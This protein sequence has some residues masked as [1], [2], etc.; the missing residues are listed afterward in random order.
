LPFCDTYEFLFQ[1]APQKTSDLQKAGSEKNFR[2][3]RAYVRLTMPLEKS[4]TLLSD[5]ELLIKW[6]Y[7]V[8]KNDK[9]IR[10]VPLEVRGNMDT[11][12]IAGILWRLG[13]CRKPKKIPAPFL[14]I[15]GKWTTIEGKMITCVKE[16]IILPAPDFSV[17]KEEIERISWIDIYAD[18]VEYTLSVMSA[19]FSISDAPTP[20]Y[21]GV[22]EQDQE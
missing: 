5:A 20:I 2:S 22:R 14:R 12:T 10:G 17:V 16:G 13:T 3:S 8:N 15:F 9:K 4:I 6:I 11:S 19:P 18:R 21:D 7:E 1:N